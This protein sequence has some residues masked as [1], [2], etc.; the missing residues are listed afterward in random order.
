[1]RLV[2]VTPER[3]Q[4][5]QAA[6]LPLVCK[7]PIQS[8]HIRMPGADLETYSA[9]LDILPDQAR[10]KVVVHE[11]HSLAKQYKLKGLH[12]K[13]QNYP[14]NHSIFGHII[15]SSCHHLDQLRTVSKSLEYAFLSPVFDSISKSSYCAGFKHSDIE[16]AL[17]NASCPIYALGGCSKDN[18]ATISSLGF[19]GLACC[20]AIWNNPNP[21]N[22]IEKIL[23]ACDQ[24]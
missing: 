24:S 8:L 19:S 16:Q 11:Q 4:L 3:I 6:L 23:E 18:V 7:L 9:V 13:D 12:L 20:G 17:K 10:S 15:S 22:E 21:L 2:V 14:D 1:M 5:Q